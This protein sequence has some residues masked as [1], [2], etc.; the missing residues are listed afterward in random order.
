MSHVAAQT[1]VKTFLNR[2]L[3]MPID[4]QGHLFGLFTAL[5]AHEIREA[6]RRQEYFE[7]K[8]PT[9]Y[10]ETMTLEREERVVLENQRDPDRMVVNIAHFV[11]D[12]GFPFAK[13]LEQLKKDR[14]ADPET[15]SGFFLQRTLPPVNN[16]ERWLCLALEVRPSGAAKT[17]R[18][19][20][21]I[22][23]QQFK[24]IRPTLG[25]ARQLKSRDELFRVYH[26][27][28]REYEG[29]VA[30]TWE[31]QYLTDASPHGPTRR[32]NIALL[33]GNITPVLP[34]V[35]G[36]VRDMT[37]GYPAVVRMQDTEER[38]CAAA[39]TA[40][41]GG[42][43]ASTYRIGIQMLIYGTTEKQAAKGKEQL[44]EIKAKLKAIPALDDTEEFEGAPMVVDLAGEEEEEEEEGGGGG[45]RGVAR[46]GRGGGGD[47]GAAMPMPIKRA[48]EAANIAAGAAMPPSARTRSWS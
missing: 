21:R 42:C 7:G 26:R 13:A 28:G 44:R 10:A 48:G 20:R 16:G 24:L 33:T 34:T 8:I 12:Q 27:L 43:A 40:E 30:K 46:S 19:G 29:M 36:I 35:V 6:K 37:R 5:L 39:E 22:P 2:I 14:D 3:A 25:V 45:G 38:D 18:R 47:S 32:K 31:R 4:A 23:A 9:V 41:R 11:A 17:T 1:D 15:E